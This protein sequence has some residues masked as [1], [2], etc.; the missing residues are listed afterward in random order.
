M[1]ER[2]PSLRLKSIDALRGFDMFWISS[3]E[4]FFIALFTWFGTPFFSFTVRTAR[5]SEMDRFYLLRHHL[6]VVPVYYGNRDAAFAEE[7]A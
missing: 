2:K 5:S 1:E 4:A 3:G 7:T 6:S